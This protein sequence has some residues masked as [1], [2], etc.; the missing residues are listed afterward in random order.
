M[1]NLHVEYNTLSRAD[2]SAVFCDDR[3]VFIVA[4]YGP[5]DVSTSK[6]I[7]EKATVN[8]IFKGRIQTKQCKNQFIISIYED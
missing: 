2:G 6:E 3:T 5:I 1:T 8:C 7:Y 4:V